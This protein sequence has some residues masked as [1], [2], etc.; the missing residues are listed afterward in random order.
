MKIRAIVVFVALWSS[1][2]FTSS[3]AQNS[4]SDWAEI[5]IDDL[6]FIRAILRENHPGPKDDVNPWFRDWYEQG[7]EDALRLAARA[8]DYPGYFFAIK[9]YMSGFQ[10]GHL[11][12]LGDD[13]LQDGRLERRWAGVILGIEGEDYVV[14]SSDASFVPAPPVGARLIGCDERSPGEL[15]EEILEP[16]FP[17]WSVRS[18]R[19]SHAPFLLVDEGCPFTKRPKRCV[20]DED[21]ERTSRELEWREISGEDLGAK[22]DEG[23]RPASPPIELR[24][25]AENGYWISVSSF[26]GND[27]ETVSALQALLA[28]LETESD[29]IQT[30]DVLVVDVRGNGGG[31]STWGER[32]ASAIWGEAYVESVKPR[33]VAIDWRASPGNARFL[34]VSMR[35]RAKRQFGDDSEEAKSLEELGNGIQKAFEAGELFYR[36]N[37]NADTP[38]LT[39]PESVSAKVFFL[40]DNACFSACL[41]FADLMLSI[42]GVTHVGKETRADAIYIDNRSERLPSGLGRLG[43]SMKVYRGRPRGHNETYVP[44]HPWPGRMD[45]EKELETWIL[46]LVK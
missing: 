25:F 2:V 1:S 7:F 30:A 39:E 36:S 28:A 44:V 9:Y 21:G 20:F 31:D 8:E 4:R 35:D 15:A 29:A 3:E 38:A 33:A 10:D 17:L 16:Y 32:I 27:V 19:P 13:R 23:L 46:S 34:G 18:V 43:F 41:N 42:D 26:N 37:A 12:A 6:H 24:R 11:G 40:T 22:I 5:A 45:D 14:V